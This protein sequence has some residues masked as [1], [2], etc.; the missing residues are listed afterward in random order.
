[1]DVPQHT[2]PTRP[3]DLNKTSEEGANKLQATD[4]MIHPSHDFN[5]APDI[6]FTRES[7]VVGR[8]VFS[9]LAFDHRFEW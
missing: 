6:P 4:H 2:L 5:V 1:M 8:T 7:L 9:L 3:H